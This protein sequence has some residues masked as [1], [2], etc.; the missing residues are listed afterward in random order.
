MWMRCAASG[1]DDRREFWVVCDC[2]WKFHFPH[3]YSISFLSLWADVLLDASSLDICFTLT[4]T[5][6]NYLNLSVTLCAKKSINPR[7]E[8]CFVFT[9]FHRKFPQFRKSVFSAFTIE[10]ST[11]TIRANDFPAL[12]AA[13]SKTELNCLVRYFVRIFPWDFVEI[14]S[15]KMTSTHATRRLSFQHSATIF[16]FLF[17]SSVSWT[18]PHLNRPIRWQ[19]KIEVDHRSV[20]WR[21]IWERSTCRGCKARD[22]FGS[23]ARSLMHN[24]IM[25][26]AQHI[27]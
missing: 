23:L 7:F 24:S 16:S 20:F 26:T 12:H 27:Q 5:T 25:I 6:W 14:S 10:F 4:R 15:H 18:W 22:Y 13:M 11:C 8:S 2:K 3:I 17:L 9:L 1:W 21:R 19:L